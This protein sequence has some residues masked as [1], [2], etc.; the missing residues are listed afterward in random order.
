MFDLIYELPQQIYDARKIAKQTMQK[1]QNYPVRFSNIANIIIA[2][3]GGSGI[4]GEIL[5]SLLTYYSPIPTMIVKDYSLPSYVTKQSLFFAVSH[6]GNTEETLT[7]YQEAKKI[8]CPVIC[9]TSGGKLLEFA[10]QHNDIVIK[11]PAHLPPRTAIGYL[12]IPFL[13]ILFEL[14]LLR[15]FDRDITETIQVLADRRSIYR[16]RARRLA[17]DL[18]EKI[19]FIISTSRLLNPVA[20]RWRQE[21]NELAKIVAHTSCLPEFSHNEIEGIG[22]PTSL[23]RL[24]Y[25]LLLF[26]PNAPERN[27]LRA[28]L[29]LTITK[30]NFFKARKFLP[31]GKSLLTHIFS[32]IMQGDL[33]SYYLARER[34]VDPL[35]VRR[36][37]K[38]KELMSK[39]RDKVLLNPKN[40][41]F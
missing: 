19:P 3:M 15:S 9:I 24:T 12:F 10:T 28:N 21:F 29:T 22:G 5:S 2:G 36:I 18:N 35:P 41:F 25:L 14:G 37:D 16:V 30:G 38:L 7:A 6:S 13:I 23:K 20:N 8:S 39:R 31:D 33:L 17:K 26:D 11:I 34:K 1:I 4:G 40:S 32:L 27:K